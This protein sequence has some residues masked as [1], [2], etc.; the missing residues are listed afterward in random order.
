MEKTQGLKP[1]SQVPRDTTG[2]PYIANF[3][4]FVRDAKSFFEKQK[5]R[6]GE[7]YVY[8]YFG[9][10]NVVLLGKEANKFV[11][12]EQA[13]FF[14]SEQAWSEH[15]SD[16]FPN[17][18]ML[19][20]GERHQYHR[21]ILSTAFRKGPLEGYAQLMQP[22]ITD[23]FKDFQAQKGLTKVYPIYKKLTLQLAARVF[24]GLDLSEDLTLINTSIIQVVKASTAIPLNLP[25]TKY[26]RGI[27]ARKKLEQY[28]QSLIDKKRAQPSSDLFSK[29][30]EAKS[31]E[32][33]QLTDAEIID[34]L[35]FIL[36]AAHDTTASTLTSLSYFLAKHTEWQSAIRT[37]IQQLLA[38][39]TNNLT[40][41]DLRKLEKLGLAIKETLRLYPP[42]IILPRVSTK[43][44]EFG[45]YEFP[46][47]TRVSVVL[48]HNHYNDQVWDQPEKFDPQRFTKH[49]KEHL[50]CPHA[51]APFGAGKHHCLGFAFAE[52]Q[53]KLIIMTLLSQYTLSV[54]EG[55]IM[56][57]N[58]VPIQ[59]PKDKLP[60][61]FESI[62]P[63]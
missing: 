62:I 35:I 4:K 52:I 1:Y 12:V 54:P 10:D 36:M 24:F 42:L 17:A 6:L 19:M 20:D 47:E 48:Q 13:N 9:K 5:V 56:R 61:Q 44:L 58:Q 8:K 22:I 29:L 41:S 45:G 31:E 32:G 50:R 43:T 57:V 28:F 40:V 23:Y 26:R 46:P 55:Y 38:E 2:L 37:E 27:N 53:I 16:L 18:I 11:L 63:K 60:I 49:R 39:C 51:Y 33:D 59:E 7:I 34:H 3:L 21:N 30:C 14:S 25:F 15:L